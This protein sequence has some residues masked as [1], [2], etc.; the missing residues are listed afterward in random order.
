MCGAACT[1]I[2]RTTRGLLLF[3]LGRVIGYSVLGA[4]AALS[5][6]SI[7]WLADATAGARPLWTLFHLAALLLGLTLVVSGRQ[8]VWVNDFGVRTWTRVR[9]M[10]RPT[11]TASDPRVR[12]PLFIGMLWALMPCGL[13]YSALLMAVL[14]GSAWQ[15][16]AAMALFAAG[17]AV[18]LALGPWLWRRYR[19]KIP[20]AA[21]TRLAGAV[22]AVLCAWALWLGATGQPIPWCATV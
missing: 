11:A 4:A 19:R 16:A 7:G 3:Q 9:S 18:S 15:G 1:G 21:A 10:M 20:N 17:S 8:P 6:R 12:G 22:L 13:L 2:G 5:F 14:T